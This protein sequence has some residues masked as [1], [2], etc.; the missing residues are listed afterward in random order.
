VS[1]TRQCRKCGETKPITEYH[2]QGRLARGQQAYVWMCKECVNA[3][4]RERYWDRK[5]ND[6]AP[7]EEPKPPKQNTVSKW[8]RCEPEGCVF[9]DTCRAQIRM[10]T[11][12]PY[13]FVESRYHGLFVAEYS[14]VV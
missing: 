1:D 9:F 4:S 14:V 10:A 2:K 6:E 7:V 8:A 3:R 11:F 12:D 13:C 5:D